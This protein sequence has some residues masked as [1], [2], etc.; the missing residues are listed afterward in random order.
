MLPRLSLAATRGVPVLLYHD[1]SPEFR[2]DYTISPANFA[3]QMEW[4]YSSGFSAVSLA[5]I[6][7]AGGSLRERTVV[8]TFDDGYASF[9]DY[10][11]P[12]LQQYGF[13]ATINLIGEYVGTYMDSMGRRPMFGWDEYRHLVSSGI[14][15]L[16]CHTRN[17]HRYG[18]LGVTGVGDDVL[19]DDLRIFR[20]MMREQTGKYPDILAWPYGM[21]TRKSISVAVRSGFRHLL[22]SRRGFYEAGGN[23][24]EIPRMNIS[25]GTDFSA[26]QKYCG[27]GV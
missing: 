17:L 1:I 23:P 25:N 15:E 12:L 16:G 14:V 2:D 8:I 11:F 26:F 5:D 13:K 3:V 7:A 27:G 10:A 21:Y 22:T 6:D 24:L 18:H 19:A 20:E 4:L 9:M